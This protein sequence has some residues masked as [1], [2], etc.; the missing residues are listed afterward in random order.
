[1]ADILI[2]PEVKIAQIK[3]SFDIDR[4]NFLN[5]L[6]ENGINTV[7]L[8]QYENMF[9]N[10]IKEGT[11]KVEPHKDGSVSLLFDTEYQGEKDTKEWTVKNTDKAAF[12]VGLQMKLNPPKE[13]K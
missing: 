4:Q 7:A 10:G 3:Q 6:N 1:M 5:E 2:D 12:L 8:K 13:N 11:I 9:S